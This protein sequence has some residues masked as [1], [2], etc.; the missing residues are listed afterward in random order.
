[1]LSTETG[2]LFSLSDC[3]KQGKHT[4]CD[5]LALSEAI[6]HLPIK[7]LLLTHL[8]HSCVHNLRQKTK[9]CASYAQGSFLAL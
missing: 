7:A 3:S 8:I 4:L 9:D 5:G 2:Y 6:L 1:M